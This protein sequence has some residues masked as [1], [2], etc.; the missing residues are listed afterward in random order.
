MEVT[1]IAERLAA[2]VAK[3]LL[4][5]AVLADDSP[6]STGGIGHLGTLPSQQ[7][8]QACDALVILG[9]NMPWVNFYPKPGQARIIQVDLNGSHIGVRCP[10]DVG[11][12]GDVKATLS[13]LL[14]LLKPK[15]DRGWRPRSSTNCRSRSSY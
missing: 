9:S 6:Y 4:G 5:R 2:P 11:L 3:A 15:T 7:I 13:A 1:Q 12:V 14:P 10:V 8:M